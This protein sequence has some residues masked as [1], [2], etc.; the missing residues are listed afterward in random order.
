MTV[1]EVTFATDGDKVVSFVLQSIY[2]QEKGPTEL[3]G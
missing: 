1:M 2:L 3:M